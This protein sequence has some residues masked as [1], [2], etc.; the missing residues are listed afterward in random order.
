MKFHNRRK[1]HRIN[2]DGKANVEI[3]DESYD[4]CRIKDL[5]LTG[6]YV[7]GNFK[8]EQ[9]GNCLINFVR[10]ENSENVYM[11]ASGKIIWGND[12][13]FGL[14]FTSMKLDDYQVLVTVL[15]NNAE[16]PA[17]IL[18]QIPRKCP[19]EISSK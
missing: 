18:S 11:Q 8:H 4:C 6:M 17:I 13:G 7:A 16:L 12:D 2:F 5:S 15:I 9:A 14:Q 19:F 1:Y 3:G 10:D